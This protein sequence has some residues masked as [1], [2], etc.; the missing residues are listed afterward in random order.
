MTASTD[1]LIDAFDRIAQVVRSTVGG[2]EPALLGERIDPGSNSI[3]WLVWHLTRIQDDHV[4]DVAGQTQAWIDDGW[5]DRFGL[6]FD[7]YD[8]GYG[9]TPDE[10][11]A[12][13]G[14]G[15]VELLGYHD[16]VHHRTVAYLRTVTDRDLGRV[17]DEAWD[18]PV[19]LGVRLVSVISDDLQHAGQAAFA[20]GVLERR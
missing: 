19:T 13:E 12:L 11:G 10:V 1:L 3:A 6:P 15:A 20:R 14:V 16:D 7:R 5:S 17:V 18:P 4:S 8:T 2:L 9:H